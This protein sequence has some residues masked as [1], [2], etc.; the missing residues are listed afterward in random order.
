MMMHSR[1]PA[2]LVPAVLL[3]LVAVTADVAHC[4]EPVESSAG[5]PAA[6]GWKWLRSRPYL[7]PDFDQEV[8]DALWKVWPGP[9]RSLAARSTPDER[10]A[11]TLARYGLPELPGDRWSTR[12][13]GYVDDGRGGWVMNCLT[14]HGGSVAGQVIPGLGN[15]ELALESLIEDVRLTK[16]TQFKK[17]AHL[18]LASLKIPLGTT[19]G[20]SN[21]VVFGIVLGSLRNPD[22]TIDRS[23]VEPAWLHH[24]MDAPPLWNVR[25]KSS[26]YCDGHSPKN[27]RMLMQFILL[28]AYGPEKL[29]SWESDFQDILAWIESLEPPRY[30]GRIDA[31]LAEQGRGIFNEHCARCHGTYGPDGRYEQ[32]TIPL[33]E[34]QTD[35]LRWRALTREHRAWLSRSWMSRDGADHVELDPVGYVAPPL[36]GIW[37]SAPYFHNG[38]VPTLWHVLHPAERPSVWRRER[39][40]YSHDQVGLSVESF[41]D[42]PASVTERYEQRWFF[43]T[44]LPGKSAAGHTFPDALTE[45]RKRAVLEYLKTL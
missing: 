2:L 43:D 38:S 14:C 9:D 18:E 11:M 12:P 42:I 21:A 19:H 7:P 8:F 34:I 22:M 13:M 29:A 10:R 32:H 45:D 15:S 28:P 17:P 40:A 31:P 16:L 35:P 4:G 33:S 26:L 24:D 44:R 20:T 25:K 1:H 39:A 41:S 36:D 37:A 23:R 5:S 3:L 6:R 27:H 30:P